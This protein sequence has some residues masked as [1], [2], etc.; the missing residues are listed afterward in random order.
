MFTDEEDTRISSLFPTVWKAPDFAHLSEQVDYRELDLLIIGEGV[1]LDYFHYTG[2]T[3]EYLDSAHIVSFTMHE[4]SQFPIDVDRNA[5]RV[6]ITR[7]TATNAQFIVP[8]LSLPVHRR[9]MVD[10][11]TVDSIRGWQR[12]YLYASTKDVES[13]KRLEAYHQESAVLLEGSTENPLAVVYWRQESNLGVAVLPNPVFDKYEW[14]KLLVSLWAEKDRARLGDFGV[15]SESPEWM[16]L[17]EITLV[18]KL[19]R[20]EHEKVEVIRSLNLEIARLSDELRSESLA[21]NQGL[22]R[23]L[24]AQDRELV[25]IVSDVFQQWGFCVE[26][27]DDS[28]DG[29]QP[30]REDLR[31]RLPEPDLEWEAIVEVRGYEKSSGK[32]ADIQRMNRFASLYLNEKKRLPS[33]RLYVVNGPIEI[34]DP[35]QRPIPLASAQEDIELFA[36]EGG[37][38]ISTSD[39]FRA[40]KLAGTVGQKALRDS[41]LLSTVLGGGL[42]LR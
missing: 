36:E 5:G 40:S 7:W 38:V 41:T 6:E 19:E 18:A 30:K 11:Q 4:G 2:R 14:V 12:L 26:D 39:L 28:L 8:S 23:L 29:S 15:W 42:F 37:V 35:S 9:L 33:K 31:L 20:L 13:Q 3:R 27:V 21:T 24:T 16:T 25:A 17:E 32:T 34:S 1:V 10:L 22:R